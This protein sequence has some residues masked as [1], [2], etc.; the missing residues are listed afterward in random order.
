[1]LKNLRKNV[2][3]RSFDFVTAH[4]FDECRYILQI[5]SEHPQYDGYWPILPRVRNRPDY[6]LIVKIDL[7]DEDTLEFSMQWKDKPYPFK[8]PLRTP[9]AESHGFIKRWDRRTCR[10]IGT[11]RIPVLIRVSMMVVIIGS[12]FFLVNDR[13]CGLILGFGWLVLMLFQVKRHFDLRTQLIDILT[14]NLHPLSE[15]QSAG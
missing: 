13:G 10:V 12:V 11:N 5:Q 6:G 2:S 9:F 7:I 1:M 15:S 8:I 14:A 3:K 4:S